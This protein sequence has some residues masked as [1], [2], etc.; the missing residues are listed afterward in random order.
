MPISLSVFGHEVH[1][2]QAVVGRKIARF[3]FPELCDE[4]LGAADYIHLSE[5]F[6][7]IFLSDVPHLNLDTRNEVRKYR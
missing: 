4:A 3:S 2:S 7:V 5:T 6:R 1:V